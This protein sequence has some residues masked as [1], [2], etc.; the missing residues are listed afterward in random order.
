[1]RR[2][3]V[4][5]RVDTVATANPVCWRTVVDTRV[6]NA[7]PEYTNVYGVAMRLAGGLPVGV[8]DASEVNSLP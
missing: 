4:D 5:G 8:V 1:M 2:S 6:D 7:R 3:A